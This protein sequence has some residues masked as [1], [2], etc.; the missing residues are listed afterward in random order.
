MA[1]ANHL[2]A[3]ILT[4]EQDNELLSLLQSLISFNIY[5]VKLMAI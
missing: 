3:I 5:H 2:N 4:I 1:A